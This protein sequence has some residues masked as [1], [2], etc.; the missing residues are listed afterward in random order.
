[1]HRLSAEER[2]EQVLRAAIHEFAQHGY[3]AAKTAAIAEAA[4]ISQP[5]I[6]A[7]FPSKKALFLACQDRVSERIRETFQAAFERGGSPEEGLRRMGLGVERLL[8]D[9]DLYLCQL[10]S[11]AAAGDPEIREHVRRNFMAA[12]DHVVQTTGASP[13]RV[14]QFF[15][16]GMLL[17]IG[18]ALDLPP[19][20]RFAP[21]PS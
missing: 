21:P 2:R 14:A 3:H 17:Y 16:T 19:A 6:Y 1:M 8:E 18:T 20:Y 4:G 7:L 9:P 13:E 15:A 10:Q 5:Y 12:F 11:Y